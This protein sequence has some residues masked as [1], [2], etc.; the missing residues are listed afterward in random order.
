MTFKILLFLPLLVLS[1]FS[2]ADQVMIMPIDDLAHNVSQ[3]TVKQALMA[4]DDTLVLIKGEI[5][6]SKGDEE[7]WFK[8]ATGRIEVEIDDHLF[9]GRRVSPDMTVTIIGEVDKEWQEISIDVEQLQ[10]H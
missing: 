2:H 4:K 9:R 10:I 5:V 1:A 3:L 6:S 7:Y 8:D